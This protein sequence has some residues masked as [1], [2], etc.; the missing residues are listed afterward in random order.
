MSVNLGLVRWAEGNAMQ[1]YPF[2]PSSLG[3]PAFLDGVSNEFPNIGIDGT[4]GLGPGS[5]SGGAGQG[6]FP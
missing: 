4:G 5:V 6:T 2:K 3:L 1:A